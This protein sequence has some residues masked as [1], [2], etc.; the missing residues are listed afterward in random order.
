M[1][2]IELRFDSAEQDRERPKNDDKQKKYYSGKQKSHRFKNKI[3][4]TDKGE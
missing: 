4:I 2:E 1:T 3:L